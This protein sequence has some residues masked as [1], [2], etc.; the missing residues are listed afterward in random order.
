M[1][2]SLVDANYH[3]GSIAFSRSV[4]AGIVMTNT[5]TVSDASILKSTN[6]SDINATVLYTMPRVSVKFVLT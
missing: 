3:F 6:A 5:I 4:G 1:Y 2:G